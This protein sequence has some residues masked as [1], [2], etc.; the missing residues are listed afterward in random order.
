MTEPFHECFCILDRLDV[1]IVTAAH[2]SVAGGGL[3]R[4]RGRHHGGRRGNCFWY[5]RSVPS[6][7]PATAVARGRCCG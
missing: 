2:G 1:P 6:A 7:C 4:L 3:I 5:R